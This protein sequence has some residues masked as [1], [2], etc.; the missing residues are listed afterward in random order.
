M[1]MLREQLEPL[2]RERFNDLPGKIRL[3]T[4]PRV[5]TMAP[6]H[7]RVPRSYRVDSGGEQLRAAEA[8][9][10]STEPGGVFYLHDGPEL[11]DPYIFNEVFELDEPFI[12]DF[13][14]PFEFENG[15]EPVNPE[16]IRELAARA[17]LD[18]RVALKHLAAD[19][20]A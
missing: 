15:V 14:E 7:I 5:R 2:L 11:E 6:V 16:V 10:I 12:L 18:A 3:R 9:G 8:D 1:P 13:D 20:I 17:I 19:G 4:A